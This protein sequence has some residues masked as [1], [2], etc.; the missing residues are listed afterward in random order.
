MMSK[1]SSDLTPTVVAIKITAHHTKNPNPPLAQSKLHKFAISGV[2]T[3]ER[4]RTKV[5]SMVELRRVMQAS[6]A[7]TASTRERGSNS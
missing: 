1:T 2:P 5:S 7:F 6:V 4:V 3:F